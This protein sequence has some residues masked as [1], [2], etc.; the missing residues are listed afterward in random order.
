MNGVFDEKG[1]KRAVDESQH[2]D[3]AVFLKQFH[4]LDH[5]FLSKMP[6]SLFRVRWD[7]GTQFSINRLQVLFDYFFECFFEGSL[8]FSRLS[9]RNT[10]NSFQKDLEIHFTSGSRVSAPSYRRKQ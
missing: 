4:E 9:F 2:F 1:I 3:H 5:L 8:H 7:R 10:L 6:F